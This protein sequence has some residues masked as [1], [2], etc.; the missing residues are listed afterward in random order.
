MVT[1]ALVE[2]G[3]GAGAGESDS[4]T[5]APCAPLESLV[6][7]GTTASCASPPCRAPGIPVLLAADGD[8]VFFA[9]VRR[10]FRVDQGGVTFVGTVATAVAGTGSSGAGATAG[11]PPT[12]DALW[13]AAGRLL[14][15]S[16]GQVYA[17]A[18]DGSATAPLGAP[19]PAG[20]VYAHDDLYVYAATPADPASGTG[21]E[22]DRVPLAG[23]PVERVAMLLPQTS[24]FVLGVDASR[25]YVIGTYN[26]VIV[27][28]D[29]AGGTASPLALPTY[30]YA[31][32]FDGAGFLLQRSSDAGGNV[33][34][35]VDRDLP[36][37]QSSRLWTDGRFEL[38][39]GSSL[40]PSPF[41]AAGNYG[42]Y[43]AGGL[44][45]PRPPPTGEDAE[46]IVYALDTAGLHVAACSHDGVSGFQAPAVGARYAFAIEAP[47]SGATNSPGG[48]SI[49]RFPR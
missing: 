31:I 49:V 19:L 39:A 42:G 45:Q 34:S 27:G 26:G 8:T 3:C 32:G 7:A 44:I 24:P 47:V 35:H 9:D 21:S 29:K 40:D 41:A 20:A 37:G 23:G 48:W 16:A 5:F 12:I 18:E 22:L 30:E 38:V 4:Q 15:V 25:A 6:A 43:G 36:S 13:V 11:V 46:S 1:A 33:V 28:V 14:V 10:V 17:M 2:A